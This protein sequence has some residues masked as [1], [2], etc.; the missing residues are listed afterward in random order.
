MDIL[1][2]QV[3]CLELS[4]TTKLPSPT[5]SGILSLGYSMRETLA[6]LRKAKGLSQ[7]ELGKTIAEALNRPIGPTYAQKKIARFEAGTAAPNENEL[8]V[9]AEKLDRPVEVI[10]SLIPPRSPQEIDSL[11]GQFGPGRTLMASCVLSRARPRVLDDTTVSLKSSIE[12]K[13]LKIAAFLPYPAASSFPAVSDHINTLIGYYAR[14]RRSVSE[15]NV[16][17]KQSLPGES[18]EA[19]A[20]YSPKSEVTGSAAVLIPPI[21]RQ[22]TLTVQVDPTGNIQQS[23]HIWTPGADAD[24]ARSVKGTGAFT[25]EEHV[26]AWSAYFGQILEHWIQTGEFLSAD[27]YWERIR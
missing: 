9:L 23:L 7:E 19:V 11:V 20:L 25:L 15:A 27:A 14:I 24:L 4:N 13:N 16:A 22:Y 12:E 18:S 2:C 17:F 10:R 1:L 5:R 6:S 21:F 3:I 26:E 8:R